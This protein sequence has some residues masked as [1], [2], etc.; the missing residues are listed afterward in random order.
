MSAWPKA[1]TTA[2][3]AFFL[4]VLLEAFDALLQ[5]RIHVLKE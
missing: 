3:C 5:E 4:F 2:S 1:N